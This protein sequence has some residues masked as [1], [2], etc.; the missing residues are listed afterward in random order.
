MQDFF[1]AADPS[2]AVSKPVSNRDWQSLTMRLAKE[3][4]A[5]HIPAVLVPARDVPLIM[6]IPIVTRTKYNRLMYIRD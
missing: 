3:V 6:T 2:N 5:H 4:A 1:Y